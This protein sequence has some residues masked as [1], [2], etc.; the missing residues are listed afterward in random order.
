M[1]YY[2]YLDNIL[3]PVTP[4]RFSVTQDGKNRVFDL[5]AGG[6]IALPETPGLRQYS[7]S[8]LL[9]TARYPFALYHN[10]FQPP[11]YYLRHLQSLREN[12]AHFD[13]VVVRRLNAQTVLK[14]AARTLN[15]GSEEA[16]Y[17]TGSDTGVIRASDARTI[18][19]EGVSG[20]AASL[21][22]TTDTVTIEEMT[23]AED[24]EKYGDDFCVSLKLRQ[25]REFKPAK[26]KVGG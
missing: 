11:E 9:P 12:A 21:F 8:L 22:D 10:G 23:V 19:R 13:M 24:A 3:M 1:K 25:Y 18:L 4:S 16:Y 5:A 14:F 2:F 26:L 6:E 20:K 15:Y 7:F 17:L